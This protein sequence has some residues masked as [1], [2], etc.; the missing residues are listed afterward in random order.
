MLNDLEE[1]IRQLRAA[2][3][4]LLDNAWEDEFEPVHTISSHKIYEAQRILNDR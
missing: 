2:L 1:K 4:D 3:K